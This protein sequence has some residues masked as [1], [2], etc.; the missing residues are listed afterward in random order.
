MYKARK[1]AYI[2]LISGFGNNLFQVSAARKMEALGYRVKFDI[3]ASKKKKFDFQNIPELNHYYNCRVAL[4]TKYIPSPIGRNG[5]ISRWFLKFALG[6]TLYIDLTSA[7]ELPKDLKQRY[8]I[9]GYWQRKD[10]AEYLPECK[11]L[12]NLGIKPRVAIHVR[13]G[14]MV[15]NII[16][17]MDSFFRACL[18]FYHKEVETKKLPI[19]VYTDDP[20]YCNSQLVLG[21]DFQVMQGGDAFEDFC[22]LMTSSHIIISRS[23]Y[24]W[25]AAF[26]SNSQV[27]CPTDWGFDQKNEDKEIIPELWTLVQE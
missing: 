3:S 10:I 4:W 1:I 5:W 26:L 22:G 14:D 6:L 2:S 7:G 8:F 16:K 18:N 13:R 25:W 27:F 24:S 23:T 9:V 12:K 15:G 11:S 21:E 17:P 19:V 20:E